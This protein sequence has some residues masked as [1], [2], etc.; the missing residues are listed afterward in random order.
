MLLICL[1][2]I[3]VTVPSFLSNGTFSHGVVPNSDFFLHPVGT[4]HACALRGFC[5]T[6]LKATIRPWLFSGSVFLLPYCYASH[7]T[8]P[9]C[10]LS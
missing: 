8:L 3:S 2:S 1:F 4:R 7:K 6:V 5:S 9:V 10:C